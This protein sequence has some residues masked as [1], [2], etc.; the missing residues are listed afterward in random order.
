[1]NAKLHP[2]CPL[3]ANSIATFAD[4]GVSDA[5]EGMGG[6]FRVLGMCFLTAELGRPGVSEM[7]CP[8]AMKGGEL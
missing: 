4:R 7:H 6:C 1:M 2:E 5:A 8:E 3:S